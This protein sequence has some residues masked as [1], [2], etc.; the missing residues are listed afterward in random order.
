MIKPSLEN[1]LSGLREFWRSVF[2][3]PD[4]R[5]VLIRLIV[6]GVFI[7]FCVMPFF[8]HP[9]FLSEY[10]RIN[11]QFQEANLFPGARF[12]V[13]LIEMVNYTIAY[14]FLGDG[15]SMFFMSPDAIKPA[16][17]LDFF[18]FVSHPAVFRT[19]WLLKMSYLVFDMLC[20]WIIFRYT[21]GLYGLRKA[22]LATAVWIFNPITIFS[23]YVFGRYESI[24]LFFFLLSIL[25]MREKRLLLG[26]MA[27][28][29]CL[30]SREIF[31]LVLPMFL[32]AVWID[33]GQSWLRRGIGTL[34]VITVLGFVSNALPHALGFTSVLDAAYSNVAAQDQ[35]RSIIAFNIKWYYP[36]IVLYTLLCF[37]LITAKEPLQYR[38]PR[39]I[40]GFFLS[41]FVFSIH[42]VHYVAWLIPSLCIFLP[43]SKHFLLGIVGFVITWIAYWLLATDLGV[44]TAWLAAPVSTH[45]LNLPNLP[46]WL[47]EQLPKFT[48]LRVGELVGIFKSMQIACL[49]FFAILIFRN[50]SLDSGNKDISTDA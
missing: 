13:T 21:L 20:A 34:I 45:L 31:A 28:A 22:K 17:H 10:R 32:I 35:L 1:L 4:P 12:V 49:I 47:G 23:F 14:P 40:A 3:S 15:N 5:Y 43:V 25:W 42:S 8:C 19:L 26:C 36:I 33:T 48:S 44:F 7:R 2:R 6:I 27:F 30:W 46:I 9:D 38:L 16:G 29:L 11:L 37:Y 18:I 39:V 41:F 50:P 24:A